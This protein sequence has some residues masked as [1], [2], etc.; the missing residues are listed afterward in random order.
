VPVVPILSVLALFYLMLNLPTTTWVRFAV[1][2][3]VGMVV[4]FLY[5]QGHSRPGRG[6]VGERVAAGRTG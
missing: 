5:G 3:V 6:Y 1:W 4:Y 2:M